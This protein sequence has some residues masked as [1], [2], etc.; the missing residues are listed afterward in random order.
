MCTHSS[1]KLRLAKNLFKQHDTFGFYIFM[2]KQRRQ[3][4]LM[5]FRNSQLQGLKIT[6]WTYCCNGTNRGKG[7]FTAFFILG[8]FKLS[9]HRYIFAF[10]ENC[11]L[12]TLL[13]LTSTRDGWTANAGKFSEAM[14]VKASNTKSC[15]RDNI[16]VCQD[17]MHKHI[18]VRQIKIVS[19]LFV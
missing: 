10:Q 8:G 2:Q 7:H 11:Y 9:Q 14:C 17:L 13:N 3:W 16:S 19:D 12:T 1:S 5:S 15:T 6:T 18:V 4:M